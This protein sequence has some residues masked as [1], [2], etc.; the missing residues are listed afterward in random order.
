[1]GLIISGTVMV[2]DLVY[3]KSTCLIIT[4]VDGIFSILSTNKFNF[5]PGLTR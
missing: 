3:Y 1:M 5:L 2:A 4:T